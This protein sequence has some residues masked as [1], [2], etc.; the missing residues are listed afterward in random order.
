MITRLDR[1]VLGRFLA[2]FVGGLLAIFVI[3]VAVDYVGAIKTWHD[4]PAGLIRDYYVAA[5]PYIL[6]LVSPIAVLLAA[7]FTVAGFA[8]RLEMMAMHAA[9]RPLWR[10]LMPIWLFAIA[11][12]GVWVWISD[13]ILPKANMERVRIRAPKKRT[14]LQESTYRLDY[15]YKA[16]KDGMLFFRDFSQTNLTGTR[17]IFSRGREASLLERLDARQS[18]WNGDS[19]VFVDGI[20]RTFDTAGVLSAFEKFDTL[21][22]KIDDAKPE[23]LVSKKTLPETMTTSELRERIRALRRAG[24]PVTAWEAEVEFKKSSPWVIAVVSIIG[25][26]LAAL[27]GR[28]G[29]ALSFGVGIFV[30]FCYYVAIRTGLALGHAG[31][32]TPLQS[33]WLPHVFFVVLGIGFLWRAART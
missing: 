32:L 16:G 19:W 6:F 3:F 8:R 23:D 33:A 30:A 21:V 15:A 9:G 17:T 11:Y 27:V 20:R 13:S 25:T 22:L 10:I 5:I 12:S 24:E 31:D 7:M 18:H 26:A 2:L 4:K 28:R 1:Y 29:Q 14:A